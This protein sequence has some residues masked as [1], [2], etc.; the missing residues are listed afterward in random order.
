LERKLKE[1]IIAFRIESN[2]SK[3]E[4]L[5]MYLN[6][7]NFGSGAYGVQAAAN[8]YFGKDVSELTLPECS[9]LAGIPNYPSKNPFQ[10]YEWSKA[11]QKQVLNSMVDTGYIT[12][13]Q[14]DEAYNAEL[15]F[16]KSDLSNT[17]YGYYL[18]A[19]IDEALSILKAQEIYNEPEQAI[20]RGGLKIYTAMDKELQAYAEEY[21][22]DP[23]HFMRQKSASGETVQAA[24]AVFDH[25][26]GGIK[27]IMGGRTYEQQRGFNRATS[28]YR[29]PGSSIK[30]LTVYSPA[31][32]SKYMPFYVLNDSRLSYKIGNSIWQPENYDGVY[33]GLITMRTAVKYSVN[34]YAVQML[35]TVGIRKGY[36]YGVNFGL[37]LIDEPGTND[38]SL[39]PLAL[40]GLTK[41]ATPV[42]MAAA[43]GAIANGGIY[44]KPHFITKIIDEYGAEIYSYQPDSHR[45]ISE[46]TAWLMSN[47]LRSVVE[48]GTGTSARVP[49]V[50]TAGKTG[51]S[52]EYMDS[53]FCGFT[54]AY[55]MAVWMGFDEKYT[56]KNY[57]AE[58]PGETA[59]GGNFPAKAFSA[60]LKVAHKDY[61]PSA[62]AKPNG[63]ISI[64]VCSISGNLPGESCPSE[65]IINEYCLKG[66]EPTE[67]CTSHEITAVCTESGKPANL[68]CPRV[69][70]R[71]IVKGTEEEKC[72][73]HKQFNLPALLKREVYV[74]RDPRHEGQLYRANVPGPTETGGCPA[75][76][77]DKVRLQAD[78]KLP[79]CSIDEHQTSRKSASEVIQDVFD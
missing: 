15:N 62:P 26:S 43:Y 6:L 54:P 22:A 47:M 13:A 19:V 36:D 39:A 42:Q 38:L 5:N 70:L 66:T 18:D 58:Y 73:I 35:D 57:P 59:Y 20:Y 72:D 49:G 56:M 23:S 12:Q 61:K 45:V 7:I 40:G 9:M 53:W 63:I 79:F 8:T 48:S 11:R 2:Y 25:Q 41:G 60:V 10:D 51:T 24:M 29:Q 14:A 64:R 3:D 4:I 1:I 34:T 71:A 74:C 75:A 68:F 78:Q 55:S 17:A 46:E 31:L 27:A 44:I 21:F 67:T 77:I 30:P 65:S 52:E 69:E 50:V 32:E 37:D 16:H 33:R 28:A 76:Y